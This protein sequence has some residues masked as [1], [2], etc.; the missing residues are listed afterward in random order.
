MAKKALIVYGGW[1][2]H[3]PLEFSEFYSN[4]LKK[5]G[6]EVEISDSLKS[7]EDREHLKELDLIVP[8]WTNGTITFEQYTSVLDAVMHGTGIAGIHAGMCDAFHECMDWQFMAGGQWVAH[9]GGQHVE[10]T[11]N[12]KHGSHKIVEGLHDFKMNSEQYYMHVDPGVHVLATS[13]FPVGVGPHIPDLN[14]EFDSVSGFGQYDFIPKTAS[15]GPH[16]L[17]GI[18]DMPAAWI[19]YYGIGRVFYT[20]LGHVIDDL[21]EPELVKLIKRGLFWATR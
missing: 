11:V 14:P 12:I 4:I 17:N 3:D 10:Y 19:K 7:Y 21:K 13:K 9:P 2:G 5:E 16:V 8:H 6:F 1:D 20:S 15:T 18:V